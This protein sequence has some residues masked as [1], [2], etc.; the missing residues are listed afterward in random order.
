MPAATSLS[1]PLGITS[2]ILQLVVVAI[3]GIAAFPKLT[4]APETKFL[5]E[6]LGME[7]MGR[8]AIGIAELLAVVLLLVPKTTVFG[9]LLALGVITGALGSHLTKLGIQ[10]EMPDG[11]TDGGA[12]F[13]MAVAVFL[14]SLAILFLRRAQ[15]PVV[16]S[17]FTKASPSA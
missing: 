3:L 16:G 8:Y 17:M 9:A 15:L 13:G 5:F 11:T 7:P 1:K 4:G 6:T 2:W 10:V 12:M 14:A